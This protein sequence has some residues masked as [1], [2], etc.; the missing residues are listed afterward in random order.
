[1][2]LILETEI[3]EKEKIANVEINILE[4]G[5]IVLR[6][7]VAKLKMLGYPLDHAVVS[8]YSVQEQFFVHCG[9]DPLPKSAFVPAYEIEKEKVLTIKCRS[10]ITPNISQMQMGTNMVWN[11]FNTTPDQKIVPGKVARRTKERKIGTYFVTNFKKNLI[12]NSFV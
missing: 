11:N 6:S 8:Y 5:D 7:L 10:T 12:F 2:I 9:N 4:N 3:K 1:M